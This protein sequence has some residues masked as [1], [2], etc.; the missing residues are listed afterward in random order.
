MNLLLVACFW[1]IL[2]GLRVLEKSPN[3]VFHN[4]SE[5]ARYDPLSK[6]TTFSQSDFMRN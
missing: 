3:T 2:S 5:L 4:A 6:S 1:E